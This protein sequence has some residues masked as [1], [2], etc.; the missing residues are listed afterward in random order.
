MKPTG[1]G[2]VAIV[3]GIAFVVLSAVLEGNLVIMGLGLLFVLAGGLTKQTE[4]KK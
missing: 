2:I 4:L 3:V 1:I